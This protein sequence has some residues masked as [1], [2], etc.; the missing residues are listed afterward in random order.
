MADRRHAVVLLVLCAVMWSTGGLLIKW[1]AGRCW[2]LCRRR[3]LLNL[4]VHVRIPALEEGTQLPVERLHARLQ[5]QMRAGF[6][7][8]H[9]R[10]GQADP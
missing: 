8:L 4:N 10:V 3:H 7:P 5:Q 2:G 1:R 6:G 9:R